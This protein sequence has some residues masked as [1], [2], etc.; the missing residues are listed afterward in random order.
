MQGEWFAVTYVEDS[1]RENKGQEFYMQKN[2]N[3]PNQPM[4]VMNRDHGPMRSM[5]IQGDVV[6]FENWQGKQLTSDPESLRFV[7]SQD[8]AYSSSFKVSFTMHEQVRISGRKGMSNVIHYFECVNFN[9]HQNMHL[10]CKW[11]VD[12]EG[13][14]LSH[15]GYF[16]FL[17]RQAWDQF[18]AC[19]KK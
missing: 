14:G 19:G 2:E 18:L 1:G 6:I 9:R 11:D 15:K 3:S 8:T 13:Y 17:T 7:M 12:Q 16:G 4:G 5:W 10:Q